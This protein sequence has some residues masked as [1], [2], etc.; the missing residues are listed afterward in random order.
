M[1]LTPGFS[2]RLAVNVAVPSAT[3]LMLGEVEDLAGLLIRNEKAYLV[4]VLVLG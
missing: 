3:I 1:R 2:I 4:H